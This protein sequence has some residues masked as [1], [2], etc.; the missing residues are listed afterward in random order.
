MFQYHV[1]VKEE[2]AHILFIGDID[3]DGTEVMEDEV[4]PALSQHKAVVIDFSEVHFVDSSGIGLLIKLVQ[5]LQ[6]GEVKVRIQHIRP[7]VN[8]VFEL[9]Q[10]G[11]ILG[12]EVFE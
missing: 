12:P 9:L 5:T 8:E 6:E 7:E 10:I 2:T 11:E 3:I 4:Q 1:T